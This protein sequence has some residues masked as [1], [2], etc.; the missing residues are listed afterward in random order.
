MVVRNTIATTPRPG[1]RERR[2]VT[3]CRV[4]MAA[5]PEIPYRPRQGPLMTKVA[6]VVLLS[7]RASLKKP[8][9]PRAGGA[10][11]PIFNQSDVRQ[12]VP[13][14]VICDIVGGPNLIELER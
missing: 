12:A 13:G 9:G 2:E 4:L 6:G 14:Q 1:M 10:G 8:E 7:L 5:E 3:F 11:S